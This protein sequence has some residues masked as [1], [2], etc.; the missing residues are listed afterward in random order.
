[1]NT[2][3]ESS[4]LRGLYWIAWPRSRVQQKHY[5][6]R[7]TWVICDM[8]LD[9]NHVP[10]SEDA[11]LKM[12]VWNR[13]FGPTFHPSWTHD[14]HFNSAHSNDR[15]IPVQNY[16]NGDLGNTV[17]SECWTYHATRN[18]ISPH[19]PFCLYY[20]SDALSTRLRWLNA[21]F[22]RG[23]TCFR[24]IARQI[25]ISVYCKKCRTHGIELSASRVI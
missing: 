8:T 25:T 11:C 21:R 15:I 2:E 24:T 23:I 20:K 9:L 4:Q 7:P 5:F 14:W 17:R 12:H 3:L 16:R 6:G 19:L 18:F 22:L 10:P 13:K 1:M